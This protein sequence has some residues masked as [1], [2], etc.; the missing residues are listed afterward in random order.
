[1]QFSVLQKGLLEEPDLA[2]V[3][4]QDLSVVKLFHLVTNLVFIE[5]IKISVF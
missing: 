5:V 3:F 1:M 2:L 4:V